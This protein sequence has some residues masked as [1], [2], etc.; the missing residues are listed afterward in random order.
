MAVRESGILM[1]ITS[2]PGPY[3]VG[4]MGRYACEFVDFLK[5]DAPYLYPQ[6]GRLHRYP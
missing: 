5:P 3:G 4:A 2:L 6:Y 1:Y